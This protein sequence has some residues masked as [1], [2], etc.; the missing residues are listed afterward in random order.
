MTEFTLVIG[1]KNYSSWSLRP[2]LVMRQAGIAFDEKI[3][4]LWL[5]GAREE[6]LSYSPAGKVPILRHGDRVIWESLAICEYLAEYLSGA[7]LW[8]EDPAIRAV[9]RAV[10]HEMHG[11]FIP[12]R[13]AMPMN[14]RASK[15]GKGME[16]GVADDIAR[17]TA[18]WRDCR[19]RF[20]GDGD[21]LFGEFTIADAMFA[22]I[23]SR[24]TTYGVD[25]DP[26]SE[27]Y[28]N[29]I[30]ALP[31]MQAWN[32]AARTEPWTVEKFEI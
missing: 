32:D 30:Q 5:N 12:L 13:R 21:F 2:W 23:V 16:D 8:P 10:S 26:V 7:K 9:A 3:I 11:G 14:C 31:A 18:I 1:N 17:I 29:A 24:L 25:T 6:I 4:A 15:P 22:P 28:M 19:D 20:G 27:D